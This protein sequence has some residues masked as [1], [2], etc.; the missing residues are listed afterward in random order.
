MGSISQLS[1]SVPKSQR[2]TSQKVK[3]VELASNLLIILHTENLRVLAL[4]G[5][6]CYVPCPNEN[7]LLLRNLRIGRE[8][9][10]GR[11]HVVPGGLRG[12]V[13]Y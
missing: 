8:T 7:L 6:N 2:R 12:S 5:S 4:E 11:Q 1:R 10:L 13:T 3:P 9:V